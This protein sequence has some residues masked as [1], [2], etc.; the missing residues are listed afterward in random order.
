ALRRAGLG[1][2]N[3]RAACNLRAARRRN[4]GLIRKNADTRTMASKIKNTSRGKT[5]MGSEY[6]IMITSSWIVDLLYLLL[7][8][9]DYSSL[10]QIDRGDRHTQSLGDRFPAFALHGGLPERLPGRILEVG[11]HLGRSPLEELLLV[12]L[13]PLLIFLWCRQLLQAPVHSWIAAPLA[14]PGSAGPE[15]TEPIANHPEKP[16]SK[17]APLGIVFQ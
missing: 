8:P 1:Q 7:E 12:L 6:S 2:E 9:R 10:G 13:L 11:P 3:A 17:R 15:I 4:I 5:A 14:L 16:A